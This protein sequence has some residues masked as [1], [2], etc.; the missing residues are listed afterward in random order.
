MWIDETTRSIYGFLVCWPIMSIC[1]RK[2]LKSFPATLL[3]T[4]YMI[5]AWWLYTL[6]GKWLCG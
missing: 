5:P 2:G 3:I 4:T 6:L 1:Q